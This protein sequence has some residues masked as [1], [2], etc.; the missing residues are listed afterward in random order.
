VSVHAANFAFDP[1]RLKLDNKLPLSGRRNP[2]DKPE[3]GL[4]AFCRSCASASSILDNPSTFFDLGGSTLIVMSPK[5]R[6]VTTAV[7]LRCALFDL[8]LIQIRAFAFTILLGQGMSILTTSLL[9]SSVAF[10]I[11]L[12]AIANASRQHSCPTGPPRRW[13][14]TLRKKAESEVII[15]DLI[16]K[17]LQEQHTIS[18]TQAEILST[19][20][21]NYHALLEITENMQHTISRIETV[22]EDVQIS[23]KIAFAAGFG[24]GLL[25]LLGIWLSPFSGKDKDKD[26]DTEK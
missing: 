9:D 2:L 21:S 15:K 22:K 18:K 10:P 26:D 16:T 7:R 3:L 19:Q 17:V 14:N 20:Q 24:C 11:N 1:E 8:S 13:P 5:Y 25:V 12:N 6:A 4:A 23:D